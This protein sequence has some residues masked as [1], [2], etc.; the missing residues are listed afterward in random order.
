[1]REEDLHQWQLID[2]FRQQLSR[3]APKLPEA[4]T[5]T[6]PAR[7]LQLADYLSLFLFALVNP[8]LATTRALCAASDLS[9]VQRDLCSRSVSLGSFSEAQHLIEPAWLERL[10]RQL[11]AQVPGP[12]PRDPH[13]AWQQWFARAASHALGA[14]RR[15]QSQEQWRTQQRGATAPVLPPAGG[16]TRCGVHHRRQNLRT[17]NLEGPMG[18]GCS[19]PGFEGCNQRPAQRI[20]RIGNVAGTRGDVG[21]QSSIRITRNG[22]NRIMR[23]GF[24]HR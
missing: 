5:W 17:Q 12:A 1:L 19:R 4:S 16:Q 10:F 11:A 7:K 20:L 14:F 18:T 21:D 22:F 15:G 8:I 9:R 3:L 13:Q 24:A 23:G 2:A 6:D